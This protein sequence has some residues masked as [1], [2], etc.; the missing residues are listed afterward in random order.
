FFPNRGAAAAPAAN[1][2]GGE[3]SS[4]S[5]VIECPTRPLGG[6]EK[7]QRFIGKACGTVVV[8]APYH[9][10]HGALTLE[11]GAV[12]AFKEGAS[13]NVGYYD[14]AKLLVRG[15]DAA[16]VVFK[17]ADGGGRWQGLRLFEHADRSSIDHLVLEDAGEED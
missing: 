16:P 13:L 8:A 6:E 15:T 7:R 12:L 14:S 9:L 4:L 11:A 1:A 17:A 2:P 5:T 3:E 10:N